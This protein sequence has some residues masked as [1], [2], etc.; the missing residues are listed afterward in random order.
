MQ[1]IHKTVGIDVE[2][3]GCK[4]ESARAVLVVR[5]LARRWT[6]AY[7]AATVI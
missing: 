7:G 4:G 2:D 6:T 3:R 5:E 1:Y